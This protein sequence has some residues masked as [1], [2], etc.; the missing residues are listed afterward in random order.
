MDMPG[1]RSFLGRS[2]YIHKLVYQ[3][4]G[5]GCIYTRVG[6]Q[7]KPRAGKWVCPREQVYQGWGG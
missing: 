5:E 2:G 4:I 7:I 6:Y 3:G 1:P